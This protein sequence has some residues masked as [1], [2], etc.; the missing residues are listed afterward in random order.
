MTTKEATI[1]SNIL[2]YIN[3]QE[4]SKAI[5]MPAPAVEN[6]TPDILACKNGRTVFIEV[7]NKEGRLEQIQAARVRQWLNANAFAIIIDSLDQFKEAWNMIDM[8]EK[9]VV[10]YDIH[11]RLMNDTDGMGITVSELLGEQ[12]SFLR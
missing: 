1:Q 7:K 5:N 4:Y 12:A 9:L 2:D 8:G 11:T 3:E 6:G 10:S